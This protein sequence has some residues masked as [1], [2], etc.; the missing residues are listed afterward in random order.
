MAAI[1]AQLALAT[2]EG[3]DQVIGITAHDIEKLALAGCLKISDRSFNQM[4]GAIE[5]MMVA[6]V[7]P[8]AIRLDALEPGVQVTVLILHLSVH[9]DDLVDTGFELRVLPPIE[10]IG[11][12]LDRLAEIRVPEHLRGAAPGLDRDDDAG[13]RLA[14]VDGIKHAS[15]DAAVEQHFGR[16]VADRFLA[17][18]E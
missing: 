17:I 10:R 6:Q 3:L 18:A 8:S 2:A 15:L 1:A 5:F 7:G 16:G 4:P 13:A 9:V 14:G 11:H 12:R